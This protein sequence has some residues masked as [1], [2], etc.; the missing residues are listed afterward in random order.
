MS[1]TDVILHWEDT[2]VMQVDIDIGNQSDGY[3]LTMGGY[4]GDAGRY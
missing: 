4:L 1:V 2:W 3:R